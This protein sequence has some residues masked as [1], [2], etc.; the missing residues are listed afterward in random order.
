MSRTIHE[1]LMALHTI[2]TTIKGDN[3]MDR[4]ANAEKAIKQYVIKA[5]PEKRSVRQQATY[6]TGWNHCRSL[7]I[8]ELK[9]ELSNENEQGT[10]YLG[11][12][13]NSVSKI[14]MG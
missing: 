13:I 10:D 6:A 3:P 7:M 8:A 9:K 14:K 1:V 2:P 12:N 11:S 4:V 5:I